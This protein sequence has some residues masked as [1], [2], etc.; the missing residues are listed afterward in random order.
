MN[1]WFNGQ[2]LSKVEVRSPTP[3]SKELVPMGAGPLPLIEDDEDLVPLLR[4]ASN[5]ELDPLVA[6]IVKKGGV[7]AQLYL[8]RSYREHSVSGN[9]K[10][11][12]DDIAAEIQ[13]FGANTFWSH[14]FRKGRGKKY[15]K[16]LRKVARRCGVKAGSWN[17]TAE[18][19]ENVL[20]AV[21]SKAYDRMTIEDRHEV[22]NTLRI[23]GL[24]GAGALVATGA[25][26]AAIQAGGDLHLTSWQSSW[27]T[28]WQMKC[29][30]MDSRSLRTRALR[31]PL[32]CLPGRLAGRSTPCGAASLSP[33]LHT[34]L[35][36]P[37]W[38]RSQ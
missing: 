11:Y 28:V 6:Y 2:V 21:L 31:N 27:P 35:R 32:H 30:G 13:K 3:T 19:E 16:I 33:D 9:H 34:G 37:A 10:M 29:W 1:T 4:Q 18:I 14:A 20:A 26:Q 15:R 12:A 7:T 38:C 25:L 17:E 8:T 22:L 23:H 5:E 24:P 36:Y